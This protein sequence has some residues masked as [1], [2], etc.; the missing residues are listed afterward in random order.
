MAQPPT[1][2]IFVYDM[3]ENTCLRQIL[4]NLDSHC[5]WNVSRVLRGEFHRL[6]RERATIGILCFINNL[7]VAAEAACDDREMPLVAKARFERQPQ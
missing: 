6:R 2:T 1:P 7:A 4:G 5:L 3:V